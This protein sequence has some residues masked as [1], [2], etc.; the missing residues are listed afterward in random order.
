MQ[1]PKTVVLL[2][3][4][5]SLKIGEH[6][7]TLVAKQGVLRETTDNENN[8]FLWNLTEALPSLGVLADEKF[9]AV[10][11]YQVESCTAEDVTS[12]SQLKM[13]LPSKKRGIARSIP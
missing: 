7:I 11:T 1:V 2:P 10:A 3:K 12:T 5:V 6:L 8:Y 9:T 13:V 4:Q